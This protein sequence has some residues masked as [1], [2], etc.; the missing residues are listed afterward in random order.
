MNLLVCL[1]LPSVCLVHRSVHS[2]W[3]IL[4][5]YYLLSQRKCHSSTKAQLKGPQTWISVPFSGSHFPPLSDS[6]I[7]HCSVVFLCVQLG[8]G[9]SKAEAVG[10][11][12]TTRLMKRC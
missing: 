9:P 3:Q 11:F 10:P 1:Y 7:T 12:S 2:T 4:A 5:G 6:F 8:L